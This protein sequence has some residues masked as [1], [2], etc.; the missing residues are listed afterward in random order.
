[1]RSA[2][3]LKIWMTPFASVAIL[4]KLALLKIAFCKA[5]AVSRA[6]CR[7]PSVMTSAVPVTESELFL[8]SSAVG[9]IVC[10]PGL[11]S[12]Q[13]AGW[14]E[15]LDAVADH[16]GD[17]E[18]G[19][20]EQQARDAPQ[21]AEEQQGDEQHCGVHAREPA[22]QPGLA[23]HADTGR[24]QYRHARYSQR[25]QRRSELQ[26]AGNTGGNRH[27]QRTQVGNEVQHAGEY[28]P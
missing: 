11:P 8:A 26:E 22:L 21:P 12:E 1:M 5:P 7:R 14:F 13:F 20:T 4:E 18:Q 6:S 27:Q 19:R 23:N 9:F 24:H 25:P 2:P 28:A 16:L 3:T 17:R 10:P 15:R